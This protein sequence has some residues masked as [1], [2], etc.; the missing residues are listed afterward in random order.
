VKLKELEALYRFD[1]SDN[2]VPPFLS[3]HDVARLFTEA[4]REACERAD[5]I[6]EADDATICQIPIAIGQP[7][8]ELDDRIVRVTAAFFTPDGC[9]PLP[10]RLIVDRR[11]LDG[12][13]PRWRTDSCPPK[14]LL[15]ERSHARLA[16]L[17]DAAGVVSL[18]CFR[19]PNR[20][21]A[22]PDDEPEIDETHHRFLVHWVLKRA[23]SRP[24]SD[25][26]N[27]GG[28]TAAE[29]AFN[30]H[31]GLRVD[32]DQRQASEAMPTYNQAV[33]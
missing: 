26:M 7:Q 20:P 3:S 1:A 17:P 23:F 12:I 22:K 9:D 18:E 28:A 30:A 21:L 25:L 16:S 2:A 4:E 6:R 5:L 32:F 27:P 14:E 29:D 8:F 13:R 11:Q 15:I 10:L 24:D 33:W 31:F 19:R